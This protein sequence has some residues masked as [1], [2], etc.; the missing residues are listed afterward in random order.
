M[1]VH[2]IVP[3]QFS[4]LSITLVPKTKSGNKSDSDYNLVIDLSSIFFG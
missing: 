1:L 3:E 4:V 2:G